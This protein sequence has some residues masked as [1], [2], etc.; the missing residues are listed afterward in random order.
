MYNLHLTQNEKFLISVR[1]RAQPKKTRSSCAPSHTFPLS[2]VVVYRNKMVT[3][4]KMMEHIKKCGQIEQLRKTG[5][6]S[7][8]VVF[9]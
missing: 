4:E 2:T 9:R 8:R 6:R 5:D 3:F 7:H 1:Q